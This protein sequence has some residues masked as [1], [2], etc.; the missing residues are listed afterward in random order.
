M[1][2]A[3]SSRS[4][5]SSGTEIEGSREDLRKLMILGVPRL[6]LITGDLSR[7]VVCLAL[8]ALPDSL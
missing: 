2:L 1:R 3:S 6:E 5:C 8:R 4:L 7:K